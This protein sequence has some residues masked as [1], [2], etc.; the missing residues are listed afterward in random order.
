MCSLTHGPILVPMTY[1]L[2]C[3]VLSIKHGGLQADLKGG[4]VG[5]SPPIEKNINFSWAV[6]T[7]PGLS[8]GRPGSKVPISVFVSKSAQSGGRGYRVAG[9]EAS[10]SLSLSLSLAGVGHT[11]TLFI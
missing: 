11:L 2:M 8:L 1:L 6:Q 10:R 5:R 3:R 7:L 4:L 9:Y